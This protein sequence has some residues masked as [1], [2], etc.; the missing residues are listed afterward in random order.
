MKTPKI[1]LNQPATDVYPAQKTG[2]LELLVSK[3][4]D[5]DG[6]TCRTGSRWISFTLT[7]DEWREVLACRH[8]CNPLVKQ[9]PS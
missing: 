3:I 2:L 4:T 6:S 8:Q 7:A 5:G 9:T 1:S